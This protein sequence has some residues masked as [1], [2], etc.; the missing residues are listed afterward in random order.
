NYIKLD[1]GTLR[2]GA[3]ST[4]GAIAAS[5]VVAD[6]CNLLVQTAKQ[7]GDPQVRNRGTIGG[8]VTHADPAADWPASILALDAKIQVRGREGVRMIDSADFFVDML[9]SAVQPGEIVTEIAV[10]IP[11]AKSVSCYL[12]VPQSASGFAIV[13][14]A[15]LMEIDGGVCRDARVGITGLSPK[16]YRATSV[17]R[18]LRN[19]TLNAALLSS[20][21]ALADAEAIDAMEDIHASG[22]YR[23]HLARVHTRRAL[24]KTADFGF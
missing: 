17:E 10:P 5:A 6:H 19:Q 9:T 23:R 18:A 16:A 8:S 11:S 2:I 15:V 20:A 22:D 24:E 1:G 14:V 13:G 3:L 12:K 7:I 21:A 4:H